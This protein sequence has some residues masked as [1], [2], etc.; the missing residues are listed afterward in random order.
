MKKLLIILTVLLV[1]GSSCKDFLS[2]D[3]KNPNSASSVPANL[4]LP[5]ALNN[6]ARLM[7]RPGNLQAVYLWYGCWSISGGY[8]QD[9]NL[10]GYNLTNGHYQDM[11]STS[12]VT[13]QNYDYII[14]QS[15]APTMRAYKAISI[16]MEA[17][18][19]GVLVDLYNNVAYSEALKTDQGILKP[20]YDDAK[21]IYEDLVVKL[22]TA[23]ALIDKIPA[24]ADNPTFHDIIYA[25]DMTKWKKFANTL[26]LKLL[27]NQSNMS[28]RDAYIT[29]ALA[30]TGHT[31][32][33]YI[34]AGESAL[35]NPGYSQSTGKMN[36]FYERFYTQSGTTQ[37]DG[38]LYFAAGGDA[39]DFLTAN[40]DPRKLLIF[41]PYTG[42][43][44]GG[45]YYGAPLLLSP[46]NTS[47]IGTGLIKTFNAGSPVFMDFE[48]LFLQAEA[49]YKGFL[50]DDPQALYESAVTRSVVY[51]GGTAA[52]AATYLAQPATPNVNWTA[53]GANPLKAIFTQKWVAMNGINPVTIWDDVRRNWNYTTNTTYPDFIHWS[54]DIAKLNPTPCVRLLYPQTEIST[55]NDNVLLQGNINLFTSR[56]FWMPAPTK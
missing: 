14:K 27:M 40:N 43:L 41:A 30:T 49:A 50:T 13:L 39:C 2:V 5:A 18:H 36:P 8:S 3:E 34:G 16:I 31:A 32:A 17:Y 25:G 33:D 42:T 28:G 45:N 6:T 20:K 47:H 37:A 12:Y 1:L 21:T 23:M 15:E 46:A 48:S 35:S 26:K 19:Y 22:D 56:I 11:W 10:T 38:I 29:A 55:N 9:L 51:L 24:T 54:A 52:A 4:I 7:T 53:S 44:I